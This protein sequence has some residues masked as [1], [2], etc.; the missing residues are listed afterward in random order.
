MGH[1]CGCLHCGTLLSSSQSHFSGAINIPGERDSMAYSSR[2]S[3]LL[4]KV[5]R[6]DFHRESEVVSEEWTQLAH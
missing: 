4:H 1:V 2:S 6:E 5:L 3:A